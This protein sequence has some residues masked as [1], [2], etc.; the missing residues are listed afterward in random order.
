MGTFNIGGQPVGPGEP[1]FVIAEAGSNHNGD[2]KTAKE[3]IDAAADAGADAVKFQTFRADNLYADDRERVDEPEDS[4][5]TL[6]ENLEQPYEWIPELHEYCQS[7]D[8]QFMSSP[9]DEQ[10]A[11]KLSEYTPAFK[12]A[13]FTISHHPFLKELAQYDKPVIMSTGAHTHEEV[14]EAVTVLQESGIEDIALLHCIS[15]YPTPLDEINVRAVETL[16][17]EFETVVGFSDHTTNP[18]TAPAAS[19][20]LGASI[21]E[22]HFTLDKE[23]EGPDHSFALE[24]SE[25]TKMISTI[26]KTEK[27]LGEGKIKISDVESGP[28]S[29]SRRGIFAAQTIHEEEEISHEKVEVLRPGSE[30][31]AYIS[32]TE[33]KE[34][35][36]SQA[37]SKIQ[38]GEP[39]KWEDMK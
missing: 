39:I 36:G 25:L 14:K 18:A 30:Y 37:T 19:V 3:L 4:T 16:Q 34:V 11:Q 13:S 38:K 24:P 15:S 29:R 31:E 1:T 27:S 32:P 8:I 5:Y 33:Y 17:K 2:L 21:V 6:L 10:S 28:A 35:I 9:F 26:R 22:K 23:M 20:A 12:V 7:R